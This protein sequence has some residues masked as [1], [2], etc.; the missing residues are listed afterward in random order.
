M[1]NYLIITPNY[2]TWS[3]GVYVLHKL[4]H[5]L[6]GLNPGS[7]YLRW[8]DTTNPAWDTPLFD[9]QFK[10]KD[11]ITIYP[12]AYHDM[13]GRRVRRTVR[14]L[15]HYPG[16]CPPRTKPLPDDD[17]QVAWSSVLQSPTKQPDHVLML[18]HLESY[19]WRNKQLRRE[20]ICYYRG[21]TVGMEVPVLVDH[22][23]HIEIP[24]NRSRSNDYLCGLFNRSSLFYCY[25][26]WTAVYLSALQCGC[27]VVLLPNGFM[28][29]EEMANTEWGLN[30]IAWGNDPDEVE[31][32]EPRSLIRYPG[33]SR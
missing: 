13:F 15:L 24:A 26:E 20:H 9:K 28:T 21:K 7:A 18:P 6:N 29:R 5:D 33:T 25:D 11:A 27:P 10:V 32:T 4:C 2:N 1:R 23:D 3:A 16:M 22:T 17:F 8:C 31:R 30:G 19:P 12:E 14:Y